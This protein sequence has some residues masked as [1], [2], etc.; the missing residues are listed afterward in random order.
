[1][2]RFVSKGRNKSNYD[3]DSPLETNLIIIDIVL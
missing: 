2:I 1:M 3:R